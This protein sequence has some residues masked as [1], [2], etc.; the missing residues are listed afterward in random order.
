[1]L[2]AS[3]AGAFLVEEEVDSQFELLLALLKLLEQRGHWAI[4]LSKAEEVPECLQTCQPKVEELKA[5][6][7]VA[8]EV[9]WAMLDFEQ[10]HQNLQTDSTFALVAK[11]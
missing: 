3:I 6:S 11:L 1:V 10:E 9:D 5:V 7:L 2:Q 4:L 8:I